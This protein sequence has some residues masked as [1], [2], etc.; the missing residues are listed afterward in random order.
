MAEFFVTIDTWQHP[1]QP[2]GATVH[3]KEGS[4]F[5]AQGGLTEAWGKSWQ[6]I[7]APSCSAA[8][9][10]AYASVGVE[11]PDWKLRYYDAADA[12]IADGR[13]PQAAAD[14]ASMGGD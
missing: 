10:A 7:E 13:D 8:L 3:I 2:K 4:F 1:F 14:A 9:K 11:C 6:R 12:A 5:R